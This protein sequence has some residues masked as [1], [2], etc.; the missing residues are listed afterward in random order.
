MNGDVGW[1]L[2]NMIET[3][4]KCCLSEAIKMIMV[5]YNT[6]CLTIVINILR[7]YW[8]F[9]HD[10]GIIFW[11]LSWDNTLFLYCASP[12]CH[13]IIIPELMWLSAGWRKG[14]NSAYQSGWLKLASYNNVIRCLL[15]MSGVSRISKRGCWIGA[16]AEPR[17]LLHVCA[18]SHSCNIYMHIYYNN[19]PYLINFGPFWPS[20]IWQF[21]MYS[22]TRVHN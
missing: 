11:R 6:I 15:T 19:N 2:Q 4:T 10:F 5:S 21:W 17:L 3:L 13:L 8:G 16:N 9:M 1:T 22:L 12:H 14:A 18:L 7:I 20:S